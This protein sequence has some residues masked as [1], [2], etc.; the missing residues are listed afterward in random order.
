MLPAAEPPQ[1]QAQGQRPSQ[2]GGHALHAGL[3]PEHPGE[4]QRRQEHRHRQD[5]AKPD[6]P[7]AGPWQPAAQRRDEA[8]EQERQR[9][10]QPKPG[11]DRDRFNR[12]QHQRGAQ[13]SGHE[14]PGAWRRHKGRKRAG[15]KT[16]QCAPLADGIIAQRS[17]GKAYFEN[18]GQIECNRGN[19]QQQGGNHAR[20]LKL[21]GPANLRTGGAQQQHQPTQCRADQHDTQRIGYRIAPRRCR[22]DVAAGQ[23]ER[24]QA[25]DREDARHDIED[26]AAQHG[27]EQDQR[28]TGAGINRAIAGK[29]H[30]GRRSV[31]GFGPDQEALG[32]VV[33]LKFNPQHPRDRPAATFD[34]CGFKAQHI[35]GDSHHLRCRIVDDAFLIGKEIG[36]ANLARRT[37]GLCQYKAAGP[38]APAADGIERMRQGCPG[39]CDG[40]TVFSIGRAIAND[41]GER[42]SRAFGHALFGAAHQPVGLDHDRKRRAFT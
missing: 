38:G 16:P 39:R 4:R 13:R 3:A 1:Q 17:G 8:N 22:G 25:E 23:A 9:Q 28:Q 35:A 18:P 11:K 15:G 19:E 10:P 32:L 20:V 6:H 5:G 29:R 27:A 7:G 37:K 30:A 14:R 24:F 34:G 40:K 2:S 36:A 26:D 42:K 31:A 21:K 33:I 41:K 12:R